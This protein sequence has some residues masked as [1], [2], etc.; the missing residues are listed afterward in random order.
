MRGGKQ[1]REILPRDVIALTTR[2]R[3]REEGREGGR[4]G[5]ERSGLNK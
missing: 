2:P 1:G 5:F 4:D 3:E